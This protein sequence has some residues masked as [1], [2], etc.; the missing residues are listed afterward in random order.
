MCLAGAAVILLAPRA[1]EMPHG[2]AQFCPFN[3]KEK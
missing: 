2:S 1:V 3:F